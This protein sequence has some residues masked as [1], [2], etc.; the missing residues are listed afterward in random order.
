MKSNE[1]CEG[2]MFPILREVKETLEERARMYGAPEDSFDRISKMWAAYKGCDFS[3]NDVVIMMI[4]LKVAREAFQ[5]KRDNFV[6]IIGYAAHAGNFAKDE[7]TEFNEAFEE[8]AQEETVNL[9]D[10]DP[11]TE[12]VINE[13]LKKV[14]EQMRQR[15]SERRQ[16]EVPPWQP[17]TTREVMLWTQPYIGDPIYPPVMYSSNTGI[18]D[19]IFKDL[20]SRHK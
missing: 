15:E 9:D 17:K 8:A 10:D 7:G 6:D 1:I 4:L 3:R 16:R 12:V 19:D 5:H 14:I 11:A 13:P 20:L 2:E 18:L